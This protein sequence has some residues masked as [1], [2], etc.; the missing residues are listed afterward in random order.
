MT[1]MLTAFNSGNVDSY[2][3]ASQ[4]HAAAIN[5]E[6][7]PRVISD[8]HLKKTATEDDRKPGIKRLSCTAK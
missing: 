8:C 1:T 6:V 5:Q 7:E 2:K 3:Q 4:A